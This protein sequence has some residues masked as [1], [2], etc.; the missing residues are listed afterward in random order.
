M[1]PALAERNRQ[2]WDVRRDVIFGRSDIDADR[3]D[4]ESERR[5]VGQWDR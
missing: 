2:P 1:I 5:R 4:R 3:V